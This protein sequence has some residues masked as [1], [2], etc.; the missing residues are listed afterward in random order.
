MI[1]IAN[2]DTEHDA[3]LRFVGR[4]RHKLRCA[5]AANHSHAWAEVFGYASRIMAETRI[6]SRVWLLAHAVTRHA[7]LRSEACWER[8]RVVIR[9]AH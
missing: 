2:D 5:K 9:I 4:F 8:E 3:L 7:Y 6:G 1:R